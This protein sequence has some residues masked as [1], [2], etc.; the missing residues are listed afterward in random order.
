MTVRIL[1]C[2]KQ[3]VKPLTCL[4]VMER[5]EAPLPAAI[6]SLTIPY[7]MLEMAFRCFLSLDAEGFLVGLFCE[8]QLGENV[9]SSWN[10]HFPG[11]P[12]LKFVLRMLTLPILQQ[13]KEASDVSAKMDMLVMVLLMELDVCRVSTFHHN[14]QD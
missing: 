6:H 2:A 4:V 10:G 11:T 8:A 13:F 3:I 1:L 14:N 7:G 9:V 12:L 5:V